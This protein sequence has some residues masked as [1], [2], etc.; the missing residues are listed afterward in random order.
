MATTT[1]STMDGHYDD[2]PHVHNDG[3]HDGQRDDHSDG[4]HNYHGLTDGPH[5]G[6]HDRHK[7]C[8]DI[9]TSADHRHKA[10]H[11][12]ARCYQADKNK[13]L[14]IAK[15]AKLPNLTSYIAWRM[16]QPTKA[17]SMRASTTAGSARVEVSPM[18][19]LCC[20]TILRRMRRMILPERVLGRPVVNWM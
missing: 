19:S 14:G 7:V 9:K 2:H 20:S 4:S 8:A 6:H 16:T 17:P 12:G 15:A 11:G 13:A 5:D 10:A 3:H 1:A 18:L